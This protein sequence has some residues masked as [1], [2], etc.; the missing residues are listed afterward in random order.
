MSHTQRSHKVGMLAQNILQSL[1]GCD[2]CASIEVSIASLFCPSSD[3]SRL[4]DGGT[5]TVV[6]GFREE[7]DVYSARERVISKRR[8][9]PP[10]VTSQSRVLRMNCFVCCQECWS[11]CLNT[12]WRARLNLPLTIREGFL[13]DKVTLTS[14]RLP[15]QSMFTFMFMGFLSDIEV[16]KIVHWFV[17]LPILLNVCL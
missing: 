15:L 12:W 6:K 9:K 8:N 3:E 13:L 4:H 10:F 14:D 5:P 2:V 1:R 16:Y 11:W 7:G 17:L